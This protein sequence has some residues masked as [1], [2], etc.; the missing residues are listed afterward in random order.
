MD[1]ETQKREWGNRGK[2]I[3]DKSTICC[4]LCALLELSL[5]HCC[6]DLTEDDKIYATIALPVM[7]PNVRQR[8]RDRDSETEKVQEPEGQSESAKHKDY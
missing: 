7:H 8:R 6:N 4:T 3:K 5:Q 2:S 1:R